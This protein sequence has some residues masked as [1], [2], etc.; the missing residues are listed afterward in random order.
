MLFFTT[1][2][3]LFFSGFFEVIQGAAAQQSILFILILGVVGTG[4]AN[5]LFFKLIQI[6]SPVF[7]TSVAYLIPIVAFCWG[8][9]DHEILSLVQLL[10]AFIIL[11]GVYWSA[12]K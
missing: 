7:A 9:L 8:L 10:G 3:I 6:S 5:F 11:I 4:I 12:K 1:L 2:A